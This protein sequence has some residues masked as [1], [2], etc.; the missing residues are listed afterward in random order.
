MVLDRMPLKAPRLLLQTPLEERDAIISPDGRWMASYSNISGEF[1]I[2][3][4]PFPNVDGGQWQIS[5]EG[6]RW[7]L[8]SRSGEELFYV[9]PGQNATVISVPVDTRNGAWNAGPPRKLFECG[10][11]TGGFGRSYDIAPDDQRFLMVKQLASD[12]E[13]SPQIVVVRNWVEELKRLVN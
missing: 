1:Q 7:P 4:R 12:D 5:T 10:C 2:Y 11:F 13:N 8:W 6:G 9:V 3:V